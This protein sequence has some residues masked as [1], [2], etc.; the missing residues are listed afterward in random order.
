MLEKRLDDLENGKRGVSDVQDKLTEHAGILADVQRQLG[1]IRRKNESLRKS[2][3]QVK[4]LERKIDEVTR[5]CRTQSSNTAKM[6][7]AIDECAK[8]VDVQKIA[9]DVEQLKRAESEPGPA[10]HL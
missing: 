10:R 8:Q 1:E 4:S 7:Q 3:D 6:A 9:S 2:A 5:E